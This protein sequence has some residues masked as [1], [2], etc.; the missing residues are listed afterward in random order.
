MTAIFLCV[1]IIASNC[2]DRGDDKNE[3]IKRRKIE[4]IRAATVVA[5][6]E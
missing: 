4:K 6:G 5:N 3:G 1:I 2:Y